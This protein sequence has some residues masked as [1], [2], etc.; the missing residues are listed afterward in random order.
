MN[1]PFEPSAAFDAPSTATVPW[2]PPIADVFTEPWWQA[3]R[4]NRLLVR[5][6][7]ACGRNHFPPRPACPLCWSDQVTWH[8]VTGRGT[9]YTFSVVR[10]NV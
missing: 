4:E 8:Q 7:A 3:C 2:V 9:L 10:E 5:A 1:P 6:C